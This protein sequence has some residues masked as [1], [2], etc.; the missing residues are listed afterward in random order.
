[1]PSEQELDGTAFANHKVFNEWFSS[2]SSVLV[3]LFEA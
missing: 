2:Q 3:Y 1:M